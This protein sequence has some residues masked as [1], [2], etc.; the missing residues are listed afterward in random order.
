MEAELFLLRISAAKRLRDRVER[1][2]RDAAEPR[3]TAEVAAR[4]LAAMAE[5]VS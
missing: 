5:G 2:A 3:V 4:A 1:E